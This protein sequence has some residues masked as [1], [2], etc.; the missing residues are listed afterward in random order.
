MRTL[1]VGKTYKDGCMY[2]YTI[3][4]NTKGDKV[5]YPFRGTNERT[6]D[7]RTYTPYGVHVKSAP[8]IVDDLV[9]PDEPEQTTELPTV[10]TKEEPKME[11]LDVILAIVQKIPV[12]YDYMLTGTWHDYN[13]TSDD[14]SPVN[15]PEYNWRIKPKPEPKRT[16]QIGKRTVVAPEVETPCNGTRY[17][18]N[19]DPKYEFEWE[20]D[21][22]DKG[23][24]I[25]GCVYLNSQD[26]ID[27]QE[28]ISALLLGTD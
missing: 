26:A 14:Q 6:G 10:P 16:V 27:C 19:H 1:Q 18:T 17:F 13:Y 28:A 9:I 11:H 5:L 24:L 7:S 12:Q 3:S 21:L 4:E 2:A 8:S 23:H 15:Y 22:V 25:K 20:N